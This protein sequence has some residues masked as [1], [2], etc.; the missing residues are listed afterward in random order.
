TVHAA[1]R[2]ESLT[3]SVGTDVL[4]TEDVARLAAARSRPVGSF[5]LSGFTDPQPLFSLDG[6][7]C[8]DRS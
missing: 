8:P 5:E 6:A 2:I 7:P 4:M 3:K 1:A